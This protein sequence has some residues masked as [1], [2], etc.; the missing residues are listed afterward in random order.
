MSYP[1]KPRYKTSNWR[2][3]NQA[4]KQRG[5]LTVWFDADIEWL[6]KPSGK[7]GRQQVY[8]DVAIQACLTLKV[9]FGLPLRQTTGFVESLLALSGLSWS[10]PDFSTLS[11][12]QN[13]LKV[14]IPYRAREGLHLLIDSTGIKVEGEGEWQRRKHGGSKRRIWRKIHIAVDEQTLEIRALEVTS[15]A[16]GD[17]P[18]LPDLLDQIAPQEKIARV[19]ADGAYDTRSCHDA[20]AARG[21][22]AIIPPR[23]NARLWK[24]TSKGAKA[25]ND[26][27]R[28]SKRLGRALWRNWSGYH[29]RSRVEAKMNC[30]KQLGQRL[31]A[32]AFDRQVAEV[33]I[34]A[35]ILNRFTAL[36]TPNTAR[37]A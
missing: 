18:V 15:S 29:R 4:L 33:Q 34:R 24:P 14:T 37:V 13:S 20:I 12:R 2:A 5:S 28:S 35:A 36:G 19:T 30:I 31:M 9:L 23:K 22:V 32:K 7:R 8:S 17:A 21:A 16:I 26:A 10:V 3:Y 27:L 1:S 25:R 6:A 11:R